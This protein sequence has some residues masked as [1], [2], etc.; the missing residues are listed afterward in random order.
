MWTSTTRRRWLVAVGGACALGL[1]MA[2]VTL[3]PAQAP[4]KQPDAAKA[5][6]KAQA[7]KQY[8]YAPSL[9]LLMVAYEGVLKNN[10]KANPEAVRA[11]KQSFERN[12]SAR[13]T[14]AKLHKAYRALSAADREKIVGKELA[15]ATGDT[16]LTRAVLEPI[17]TKHFKKGT[18]VRAEQAPSA[19]V[20]AQM[21]AVPAEKPTP[22]ETRAL[23]PDQSVKFHERL[24]GQEFKEGRSTTYRVDYTGLY[25][26][27]APLDWGTH[28]EPAVVFVMHQGDAEWTRSFGPYDRCDGGDS[29][30]ERRWLRGETPFN[31][32]LTVVA[33]LIE[34][35]AG[36]LEEIEDAL[37]GAVDVVVGVVGIWFD[38]PSSISNAI[39]DALT[40]VA[41]VLGFSNDQIGEPQ[42]IAFD[43]GYAERHTG[44]H[45]WE[46]F[47]YDTFLRFTGNMSGPRRQRGDF[48][49]FL[50]V[51]QYP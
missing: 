32:E 15:Q 11:L 37:Q 35:D 12:P 6:P 41:D 17:F 3:V 49:V 45:T 47:E 1:G 7:D 46:R 38:V 26:R 43:R 14:V 27:R 28:C 8:R 34:H 42:M 31:R 23:V 16:R 30:R 18:V 5:Q 20:P 39:V 13:Q 51:R 24:V 44:H 36:S 50:D 19:V 29:Y 2:A 21:K 40:W 4:T 10:E 22:A 48:Y 9:A 33:T 25:C